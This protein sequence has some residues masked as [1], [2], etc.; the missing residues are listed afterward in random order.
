MRSTLRPSIRRV[1]ATAA[2]TTL[3]VGL[4]ACGSDEPAE[5][6]SDETSS[7][8]SDAPD[9]T[10][11]AEETETD[12]GE[13]DDSDVA[14][15]EEIDKDDFLADFQAGVENSTTAHMTMT[16]GMSGMSIDAEG[17]IDYQTE[18]PAMAMIMSMPS[19]GGEIEMRFVDGIFYM[20]MGQQSQDK[21]IKMDPNDPNSPM[22]DV[23][24]LTESMDPVRQ[25]EAFT[26]GVNKVVYV[27]E[28]DVD[29]ET[30]D[31]YVLT[32]DT[33]KVE[34]LKDAGTAGIPKELDYDLWLDDDDRIRQMQL[35]LG[36][37]GQIEVHLSD[38]DEPVDI[39]APP[40]SQIM[41]MPKG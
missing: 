29:G 32:L 4:T 41:E 6:A 21:F 33:T 23:S 24:E 40:A 10:A 3:L 12:S 34:S 11:D 1:L 28:E 16:T 13:S 31:H 20:N 9:A 30:T 2:A 17:D 26:E 18:P 22:G 5:E 37:T 39:E 38:W 36:D 15:G 25:F 19:M 27:G 8:T 7:E 14:E 35:D